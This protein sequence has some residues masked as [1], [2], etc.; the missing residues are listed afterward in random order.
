M[1]TPFYSASHP[2]SPTSICAIAGTNTV[3]YVVDDGLT[4]AGAAGPNAN[5][6]GIPTAM[7]C[8]IFG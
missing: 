3:I 8:F 1:F 6:G 5:R 4:G 7:I 2:C